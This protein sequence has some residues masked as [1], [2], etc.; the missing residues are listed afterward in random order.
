MGN[1]SDKIR[2]KRIDLT[3]YLFHYTNRENLEQIIHEHTLKSDTGIICFTE[4]PLTS[5]IE[6]FN[7]MAKYPKPMYEPYGIGISRDLLIKLGA[8]NVIYGTQEEIN[9]YSPELQWRCLSINPESYDFSWLREWRLAT[10]NFDF[11]TYKNDT[12]IIAPTESELEYLISDPSYEYDCIYEPESGTQKPNIYRSSAIRQW[13]GL[14]IE[15]ISKGI[16]DDFVLSGTTIT[17]II[18]E[19]IEKL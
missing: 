4:A 12:V 9:Q 10:N 16:T 6:M 17:Q 18:G 19:D 8:R 14:S 5:C 11:E 2:K 7:Y 3:P 13:K 1:P 15:A